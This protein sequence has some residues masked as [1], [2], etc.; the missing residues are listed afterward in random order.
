MMTLSSAHDSTHFTALPYDLR[1]WV[2]DR[3]LQQFVLETIS[4]L[5]ERGLRLPAV[6]RSQTGLPPQALLALL[7]YAY[8]TGLFSSREI[9]QRLLFEDAQ[10]R[11]WTVN[12]PI[13]QLA[14]RVFRRRWRP[15]IKECLAGIFQKV[16]AAR[17]SCPVT[18]TGVDP[19]AFGGRSH[20]GDRPTLC[21]HFFC[22][23]ESRVLRAILYDTM[24]ADD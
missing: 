8:A 23:A 21:Q 10:L 5:P 3:Q 4:A 16:W 9:E 14:L 22:E 11:Y 18:E 15:A 12:N 24:E 1:L 17:F 13:D 19:S 7:T 6:L 20:G 2:E